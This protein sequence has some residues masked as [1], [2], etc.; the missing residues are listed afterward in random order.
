M[1]VDRLDDEQKEKE[2]G[3]RQEELMDIQWGDDSDYYRN[4]GLLFDHLLAQL[5]WKRDDK[6]GWPG[7]GMQIHFVIQ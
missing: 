6:N 7:L 3:K 1:G 4:S 2:C 5:I